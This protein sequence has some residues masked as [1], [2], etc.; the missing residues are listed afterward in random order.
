MLKSK[1][2]KL[3]LLRT[4]GSNS[5]NLIENNNVA[6]RNKEDYS[7]ILLFEM[8]YKNGN[9]LEWCRKNSN[10]VIEKSIVTYKN[11][12]AKKIFETIEDQLTLLKLRKNVKETKTWIKIKN[13]LKSGKVVASLVDILFFNIHNVNKANMDAEVM[14][15]IKVCSNYIVD[16]I[17]MLEIEIKN[18]IMNKHAENKPAVMFINICSDKKTKVIIV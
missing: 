8:K 11:E 7:R 16:D 3:K 12:T 14:K 13:S 4:D 15:I 2:V 5:S 18:K 10:S 17:K 9:A 6:S 1:K